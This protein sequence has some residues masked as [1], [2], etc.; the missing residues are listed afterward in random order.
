VLWEPRDKFSR[1]ATK[2][3][4]RQAF[5]ARWRSYLDGEAAVGWE[6]LADE[7][8]V[9]MLRGV[10]ARLEGSQGAKVKPVKSLVEMMN[11]VVPTVSSVT[12]RVPRSQTREGKSAAVR[13]TSLGED[14]IFCKLIRDGA[15]RHLNPWK[16]SDLQRVLEMRCFEG[17]LSD[18]DLKEVYFQRMWGFKEEEFV[19]AGWREM[20]VGDMKDKIG[21]ERGVALECP[22]GMRD[23]LMALGTKERI[24]REYGMLA[25]VPGKIAYIAM[26]GVWALR[27]V[28]GVG[29][30]NLDGLELEER[31]KCYRYSCL[32]GVDFSIIRSLYESLSAVH[33]SAAGD[34]LVLAAG[35]GHLDIVDAFIGTRVV[36]VDAVGRDG[37]TALMLAASYGQTEI[38]N[39]LAG[40]YNA[41][42]EAV[43]RSGCTALMYAAMDGQ[44]DTVNALAGTYNANVDAVD[45]WEGKTALMFAAENGHTDTVNALAGTHNANVEAVN[46]RGMTAL[47]IAAEYG[48]TDTVNALAGT[49][50]ANVDAVNRYGMTALM[51][52]AQTGHTD[53]VNALAG[54]YNANVEAVNRWGYTALILAAW[55]GHTDTVNALAGTHN[56][57][58]EAVEDR[59]GWTALMCA[60]YNG[61]TDTAKALRAL[62]ASSEW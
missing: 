30:E 6:A 31:K 42:V 24:M 44:T 17:L 46:K 15:L 33:P 41:N 34:G 37:Y 47:M 56:A 14:V 12:R 38:V 1:H 59:D 51:C 57:N 54:A 61:H 7:G 16:L 55:N 35:E 29:V 13:E 27:R 53:T 50:N 26:C 25:Y 40:T 49:Y 23:H 5:V 18:K 4:G 21:W 36:D 43:D 60:A 45:R 19:L 58:M 32:A 62:G 39:A 48:H 52:A 22:P 10:V 28:R 8:T 9:E 3:L 11:D 20:S 2:L